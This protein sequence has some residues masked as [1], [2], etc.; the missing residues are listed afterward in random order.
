MRLGLT[1][2][3]TPSSLKQRLR[4][5]TY[6]RLSKFMCWLI[7]EM[8]LSAGCLQKVDGLSDETEYVSD[9]VIK[10]TLKEQ[11]NETLILTVRLFSGPAYRYREI[12]TSGQNCLFFF[13]GGHYDVLI[14]ERYSDLT[15]QFT[16]QGRFVGAEMVTRVQEVGTPNVLW[17][18]HYHSPEQVNLQVQRR[19][20]RLF[21]VRFSCVFT[22]RDSTKT[23]R[24]VELN[25]SFDPPYR[26]NNGNST[27][28]R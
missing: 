24:R 13:V 18:F 6:L 22:R 9:K 3:K 21:G 10:S 1:F 27:K 12:V 4:K 26:L 23:H 5:A 7:V 28:R 17:C 2:G 8:L 25:L 11:A 19:G 20:N 15:I 16:P 14:L